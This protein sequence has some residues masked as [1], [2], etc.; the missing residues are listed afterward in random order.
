MRSKWKRGVDFW[1][2]ICQPHTHDRQVVVDLG[3]VNQVHDWAASSNLLWPWM[4]SG[5]R[6][7]FALSTQGNHP[8]SPTNQPTHAFDGVFWPELNFE[9]SASGGRNNWEL[10]ECETIS[11]VV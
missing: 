6:F 7:G 5:L 10:C 11:D 4:P 3:G 8:H 1:R 2:D 9:Q